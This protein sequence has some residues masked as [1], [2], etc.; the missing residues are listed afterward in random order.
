MSIAVGSGFL[1]SDVVRLAVA[2]ALVALVTGT[3]RPLA[4]VNT[5]YLGRALGVHGSS[6]W[7]R[8]AGD[9]ARVAGWLATTVAVALPWVVING[10]LLRR[11]APAV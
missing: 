5:H 7:A 3:V 9:V 2:V 10:Q 8:L 11:T 4:V 1:I 6:R